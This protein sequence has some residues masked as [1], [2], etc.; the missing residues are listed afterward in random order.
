VKIL[1]EIGQ[2]LHNIL[3]IALV[4]V[5]L[6][7][8]SGDKPIDPLSHVHLQWFAGGLSEDG[9]GWT[10]FTPSA[11]SRLC[12]VSEDGNDGTAEYYLPADPEIG[13]DPFDPDGPLNEYLTYA[14]AAADVRSGY[15]DWILF[16]RDDTFSA[17]INERSGD[18]TTEFA[19]VSAYGS[20]GAMP[21][22]KPTT[23][24]NN[25]IQ[26]NATCQY[27]AIMGIDFYSSTRDPE[28]GDYIDDSGTTGLFLIA[29]AGSTINDILIEGCKFRFFDQNNIID[30][31]GTV[32]DIFFRRN[33]VLDSYSDGVGNCQGLW[34]NDINGLTVEEN[35]F[36]HNGWYSKPSEEDVGPATIYNHNIYMTRMHNTTIQKNILLRASSGDTKVTSN[37]GA[38]TTNL[39]I[40]DNLWVDGEVALSIGWN[41]GDPSV[42]FQNVDIT[43]NVMTNVDRDPPTERNIGWGFKIGGIGIGSI[44]DNLLINWNNAA[45]TSSYGIEVGQGFED[46]MIE[47]NI[48]YEL[49]SHGNSDDNYAFRINYSAG[50]DKNR[51][52]VQNNLF[53]E[54]SNAL[55]MVY[56]ENAVDISGFTFTGNEY[57]ASS[58]VFYIAATPYNFA[59][60][61]G[62]TGET[63]SF[64]AHSFADPTR[65]IEAYMTHLGET[66]TIAAFID[67]C[68]AQGRYS[69]D[70]D[71]TAPVVNNWMRTGFGSPGSK[72][73]MLILK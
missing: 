23:A 29:G 46:V 35:I 17:R 25:L 64:G 15:A 26:L 39:F 50:G 37:V 34:A 56:V 51:N 19:L 36:D 13:S 21:I 20:S 42:R 70:T 69:W 3:I 73:T 28:A 52:T 5:G 40:D 44:S 48:V 43:N 61:Q 1:I 57:Y 11:D 68:R 49:N 59:G 55:R 9:D 45:I 31:G 18:T 54:P 6:F 2:K 66:A 24:T 38:G 7:I 53:Q 71:Y 27:L 14:A 12:Y 33:V 72:K 32:E 16:K 65:G 47:D 58:E 41:Y 22:V 30:N 10:I 67:K 4:L 8:G 62:E 60:W 63:G